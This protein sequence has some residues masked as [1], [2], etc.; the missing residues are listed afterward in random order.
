[1]HGSRKEP[2]TGLVEKIK[3]DVGLKQVRHAALPSD[4][5][6]GRQ[7]HGPRDISGFSEAATFGEDREEVLRRAVDALET[8]IQG[9]TGDREDVP[10]PS[11]G[12]P[13]IEL[14]GQTS[15]KVLLYRALRERKLHK[16]TLAR[17]RGWKPRQVDRLLDLRHA[18][19]LEQLEAAFTALG[20][21]IDVVVPDAS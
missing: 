3:R 5:E 15:L 4:P 6:R 17:R 1:M 19:R 20:K 11:S 16:A 14:P 21:Q 18:S 2:G 8:A 13:T 10:L 9:R 7:W 12:E